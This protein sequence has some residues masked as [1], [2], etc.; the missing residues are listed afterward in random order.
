M[1][2]LPPSHQNLLSE[3]TLKTFFCALASLFVTHA[4]SAG[5]LNCN[6][7]YWWVR[8]AAQATTSD[9]ALTSDIAIRVTGVP[10]G[11]KVW[12]LKPQTSLVSVGQAVS[13]SASSPEG[14][15][16]LATQY[17]GESYAGYITAETFA[18]TYKVKVKCTLSDVPPRSTRRT[19]R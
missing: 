16:T 7:N 5:V 8:F 9:R 15:G 1:T 11:P 4:A 6:G 3:V 14:T 10:G 2:G 13:F 19:R 17:N 18:G 12:N